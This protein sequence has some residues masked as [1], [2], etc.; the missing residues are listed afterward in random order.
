MSHANAEIL[1]GEA[2]TDSETLAAASG[3]EESFL[4]RDD[5]L[6]ALAELRAAQTSVGAETF[7]ATFAYFARLAERRALDVFAASSALAELLAPAPSGG[8]AA[9]LRAHAAAKARLAR[10]ARGLFACD[11]LEAA[12]W[13]RRRARRAPSATPPPRSRRLMRRARRLPRLSGRSSARWT[14][15]RTSRKTRKTRAR[16]TRLLARPPRP[17]PRTR[18]GRAAGPRRESLF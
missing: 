8:G 10:L 4:R 6:C 13:C 14:S 9:A 2:R 16:R 3:G 5:A 17:R 12:P 15:P 11:D 18:S 1:S 7:D